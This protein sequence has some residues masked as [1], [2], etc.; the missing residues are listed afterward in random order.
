MPA[1]T[2]FPRLERLS[3][4]CR[5]AIALIT[6]IGGVAFAVWMCS[7]QAH[8]GSRAG[9]VWFAALA[10]C[11]VLGGLSYIWKRALG[12]P[13]LYLFTL[14]ATIWL[15]ALARQKW[16]ENAQ[17]NDGS[18]F[19]AAG[20]AG[21]SVLYIIGIHKARRKSPPQHFSF[22]WWMGPRG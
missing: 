1:T 2:Q 18:L 20:L 7:L 11:C 6:A 16:I 21:I 3:L 9:V 5:W 14:L 13:A 15:A 17:V 10:F 19:F 22:W 4:W 8:E 12:L